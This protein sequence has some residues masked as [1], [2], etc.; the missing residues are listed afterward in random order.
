MRRMRRLRKYSRDARSVRAATREVGRMMSDPYAEYHEMWRRAD[1]RHRLDAIAAKRHQEAER[2]QREADAAKIRRQ[3]CARAEEA[4][5]RWNVDVTDD[6]RALQ[7]HAVDLAFAEPTIR[8]EWLPLIGHSRRI[9]G[10][11]NAMALMQRGT[12]VCPPIVDEATAAVVLHELGHHRTARTGFTT[13]QA[14]CAAWRWAREHALEWTEASQQRMYQALTSYMEGQK[15]GSRRGVGSGTVVRPAR[16]PVR[17]ATASRTPD[18]ARVGGDAAA[19]CTTDADGGPAHRCSMAT[20]AAA[21]T[22]DA[23]TADRRMND[24]TYQRIVR[25]VLGNEADTAD[26]SLLVAALRDL[27]TE[28]R[29]MVTA[30]ERT[31]HNQRESIRALE[32]T[33][34]AQKRS[35]G[36]LEDGVAIVRRAIA[37]AAAPQDTP[38]PIS[39]L[40]TRLERTLL[41]G[42]R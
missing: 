41:G 10:E 40:H 37:G 29:K 12:V 25:S 28:L 21:S 15:G 33:I 14:E 22:G 17:A 31:I 18:R 35:I 7:A 13:L 9:V 2:R 36:Y 8:L 42:A 34:A 38:T 27:V 16:I 20:H 30:Q 26:E 24:D 39:E 5:R 6:V 11:N 32:D 23:T 4:A 3:W 1:E 19:S